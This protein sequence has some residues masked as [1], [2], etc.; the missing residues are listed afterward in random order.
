M[1]GLDRIFK[2]WNPEST[3]EASLAAFG[4]GTLSV[5]DTAAIKL[6]P[7]YRACSMIARDIARATRSIQL[8]DEF[9]QDSPFLD[10]L[11]NPHATYNGNQFFTFMMFEMMSRGS[12][13]AVIIRDGR[14]DVIALN[15]VP[16]G[17]W[18]MEQTDGMRNVQYRVSGISENLQPSEVLHFKLENPG[19]WW[20]DGTSPWRQC[21]GSVQQMQEQATTAVTVVQNLGRPRLAIKIPGR[22]NSA[23]L[24]NI[25]ESYRLSSTGASKAGSV[26]VLP[27]N[28]DL[29]EVNPSVVDSDFESAR[30]YSVD[31]VARLTGVPASLLANRHDVKYSTLSDEYAAY[32][33][34]ALDPIA[35]KVSAEFSKILPAGEL[36]FDFSRVLRPGMTEQ[37]NAY[38]AGVN[39]GILT[40]NEAR[41]AMNLSPAAGGD[42][43]ENSEP[44]ENAGVQDSE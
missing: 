16:N 1:L 5:S 3:Y 36:V 35:A 11:R 7:A 10:L 13:L 8:G 42:S 33:S 37:L 4:D 6:A 28:M 14:G 32:V 25:K 44:V 30:R 40:K 39:A 18:N 24:A 34:S 20:L 19:G 22:P 26:I 12:S 31:D 27:E 43:V 2:R 29:K 38:V 15:P 23:T 21:N 9:I 17:Q 41:R